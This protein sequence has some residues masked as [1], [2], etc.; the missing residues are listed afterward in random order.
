MKKPQARRG[1]F[2]CSLRNAVDKSPVAVPLNPHSKRG[3]AAGRLG[4]SLSAGC[5]SSYGRASALIYFQSWS[6]LP[7]RGDLLKG[8]CCRPNAVFPVARCGVSRVSETHTSRHAERRQAQCDSMTNVQLQLN[9]VSGDF[10]FHMIVPRDFKDFDVDSY[11]NYTA[12]IMV[13]W[14]SWAG[15]SRGAISH[16]NLLAVMFSIL[17]LRAVFSS[18]QY[19]V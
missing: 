8:I 9:K 16:F 2:C 3:L 17:F 15:L 1:E 19:Q 10:F 6:P 12:S 13:N 4:G 5:L 11:S 14:I 7:R 18:T